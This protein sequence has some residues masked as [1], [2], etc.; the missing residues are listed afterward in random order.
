[1]EALSLRVTGNSLR[2][3]GRNATRAVH[4]KNAVQRSSTPRP[5]GISFTF[6]HV[7]DFKGILAVW[8]FDEGQARRMPEICETEANVNM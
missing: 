6:L 8:H 3:P 5:Q 1:M 7:A 4:S 2:R